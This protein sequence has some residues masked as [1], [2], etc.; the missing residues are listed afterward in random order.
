MAGDDVHYYEPRNGHGLRHDPFSAIVGPRPIGWISTRSAQGRAN[1]A[2][3]SFFN[4][5]NY[6][7]P[8]IGFASV[9]WKDTV[10]N[11][12]DT[13]EF[14]WN[15][16]TRPMAARMNLTSAAVPQDEF[17]LA[18]LAQ[19]PAR[20]V[21]APRVHASPV[22]FECRLT[23]LFPLRDKEGAELESW[24]ILG[25]VIAVHIDRA[26]LVDGVYDT[27]RAHPILRAGGLG[28]YAGITENAM[29]DMNR[30][31]GEDDVTAMVRALDA[32]PDA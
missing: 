4:A 8:I 13:A 1:L 10:A 30:P 19:A 3:Y 6:R 2:P 26:M 11:I 21:G 32:A 15:L 17:A 18:G 7:P 14:V 23:Q 24:M 28:R 5:F 25:E 31:A 12:R 27:A 20:L 22:N 29:F 9:G 16:A